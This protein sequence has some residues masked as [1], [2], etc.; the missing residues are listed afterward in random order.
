MF[1]NGALIFCRYSV[2]VEFA[3][4]LVVKVSVL[5]LCEK[6][7]FSNKMTKINPLNVAKLL[8]DDISSFYTKSTPINSKEI[9]LKDQLL[10]KYFLAY[11]VPSQAVI[12]AHKRLPI[13][14]LVPLPVSRESQ[15]MLQPWPMDTRDKR[16]RPQN[17]VTLNMCSLYGW[18]WCVSTR[19]SV[20]FR[21]DIIV[22]LG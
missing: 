14:P 18:H 2:S 13:D 4:W 9:E 16:L 10:G 5:L 17:P 7:L 3:Q 21:Q 1:E 22:G 19:V 6:C 20:G 15:C 12:I 11:D 8:F